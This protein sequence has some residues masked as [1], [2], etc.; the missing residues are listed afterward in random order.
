[1]AYYAIA[2]ALLVASTV[3]VLVLRHLPLSRPASQPVGTAHQIAGRR[4]AKLS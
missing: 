4:F 1:M 3:F 2:A